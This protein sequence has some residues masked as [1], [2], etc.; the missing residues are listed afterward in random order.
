MKKKK[1]IENADHIICI[2]ENTKKDLLEYYSV[3]ENKVST[4]YLGFDHISKNYSKINFDKFLFPK[5]FILF[6]GSRQKYKNFDL[7]LNAYKQKINILN[8][9][10]LVCFGGGKFTDKEVNKFKSLGVNARIKNFQGD[11]VLLSYLYAKAKL[12]IFPSQYEGFGLPLIEAMSQNCP[13][14]A[15]ENSTFVEIA[16]DS[17]HFFKNNNVEDLAYKIEF[18][19]N[20][21]NDLNSKKF[22]AL[23]ISKKYTW[24][25][26]AKKTL[27]IYKKLL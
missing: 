21:E 15:S 23:E 26:C 10:E 13:V 22:K 6:V 20:S 3:N 17:I 27:E 1:T 9:L 4:V 2:S 14:L 5:N 18:L 25:N 16:K 24:E 11:D 12:F 8:D 19:I 7:L